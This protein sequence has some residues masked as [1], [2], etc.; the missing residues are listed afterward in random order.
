MPKIKDYPQLPEFSGN[1]IFLVESLDGTRNYTFEQLQKLIL[2]SA[3]E[4]S[5][6]SHFTP[7]TGTVTFEQIE[8]KKIYLVGADGAEFTDNEQIFALSE[9]D[10]LIGSPDSGV[11]MVTA[12][13]AHYIAADGA[14]NFDKSNY[15]TQDYLEKLFAA[16]EQPQWR[17]ICTDI[18]SD[19][20]VE[21]QRTEDENG[22]PLNLSAAKVVITTPTVAIL[23]SGHVVLH[24]D[25]DV[26]SDY[27]QYFEIYISPVKFSTTA[28]DTY[29]IN[30]MDVETNPFL[31]GFLQY[32]V[33]YCDLDD[34]NIA[35]SSTKN[36]SN[37]SYCTFNFSSV[38]NIDILRIYPDENK[39]LPKGMKVELWG[40]DT[41]E[42]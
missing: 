32:A 22:N 9:N 3:N 10:I 23:T 42:S 41:V 29:K 19:D 17:K 40:V 20:A 30:V 24:T 21:Y 13:G 11:I 26:D 8:P 36:S 1:E 4:V 6:L 14:N 38:N 15:V 27:E 7:L 16:K 31:K 18:L 28:L 35:I 12:T 5:E 2:D 33:D 39:K 37:Q 25:I 34:G